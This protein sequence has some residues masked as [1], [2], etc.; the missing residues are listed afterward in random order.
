LADPYSEVLK[1][2]AYSPDLAP[3][4]Y[5]LFLNLKKHLKGRKLSSI[6]EAILSANGQFAGQPKEFYLMG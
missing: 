5:C 6:E 2:P 1:H 4:D 3:S